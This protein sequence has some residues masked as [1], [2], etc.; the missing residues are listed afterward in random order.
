V[1]ISVLAQLIISCIIVKTIV[2]V[3]HC[4][5]KL[6]LVLSILAGA[7]T[8]RAQQDAQYTQF[9]MTKLTY[10][11]AYAGS[12]DKICA[13][14][15]Y[16]SQW[17]G[18]GSNA[19]GLSPTTFLA[20]I[21]A[22]IGQSFGIG[23]NV[24]SDQLGYEQSIN[25]MLSLAY[26]K[27]FQN[28]SV[29]AVGLGGGIMQK[30]LAG[31]K[32]KP[33]E[34]GDNKIPDVAVAGMAV[35]LNFG[36]YYTMQNAWRFTNAYAGLSATH[37]TQGNVEYS[38]GNNVVKNPMTMHYY[39]MTGATVFDNGTFAIEPNILVKS[40]LAKTSADINGMLTYNGKI[41]GGL[42]Y[43]TADAVAILAGYQF[44][45]GL[46]IGYSYDFTT[47]NIITYSSGSHEIVAKY[48]F[49]IKTKEREPKDPIIRLTPRF[50]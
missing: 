16:R 28:Q 15:L 25:P 22:P 39:F 21:H 41:R 50:L 27:H 33:L 40:D 3:T 2:F 31:D 30:S 8:L 23:L 34:T 36:L 9:F 26:R 48:C 29:L 49:T 11:P 14:G 42:T 24:T 1:R 17:L 5:K 47:S 4:M 45:F 35:D 20:N 43:R 37:L 32:L 7:A 18:F 6:L 44:P 12:E 38:W 46:Q 19:I 10:N 13:T